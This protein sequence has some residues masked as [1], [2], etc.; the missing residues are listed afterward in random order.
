MYIYLYIKLFGYSEW[1]ERK[2]FRLD[3]IYERHATKATGYI[4]YAI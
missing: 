3:K 1:R 4:Y 2:I